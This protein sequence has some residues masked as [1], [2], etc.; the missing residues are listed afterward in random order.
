[1][2]K[3][4]KCDKVEKC[5]KIKHMKNYFFISFGISFIFLLFSTMMCVFFYDSQV[6]FVER[7]FGMDG[8][9][10]GQLVVFLLGVWKILIV[11]F[12]LIPAIV[13]A[14]IEKNMQK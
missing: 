3:E 6:H 8:E 12:T 11:Q 13:F 10:Y 5:E 14:I 1:M 7:F 9:D 4:A 2:N